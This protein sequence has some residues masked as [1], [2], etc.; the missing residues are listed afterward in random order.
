MF[1]A[2]V[3]DDDDLRQRMTKCPKVCISTVLLN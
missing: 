1:N 2:A 3:V